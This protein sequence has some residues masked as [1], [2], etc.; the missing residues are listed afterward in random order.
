MTDN[1]L[2]TRI[3]VEQI[4]FLYR[5]VKTL[6]IGIVVTATI[7]T[8]IFYNSVDNIVLFSWLGGILLL[9]LTR[10]FV[11]RQFH[12]RERSDADVLRWGKIFTFF[13]FLSGCSWG[14]ASLLFFNPED[15]TEVLILTMVQ[16]SMMVASLASMS[17]VL[18][19]YYSFAIPVGLALMYVFMSAGSSEFFLFGALAGI[20]FAIQLSSAKVTNRTLNQTVSL[21][22]QNLD[23]IEQLE[24]EKSSSI[25]AQKKAE[26]A[27]AAKTKFL[28]AASHDLR[29]PLHAQSLF[30]GLLEPQIK[31]PN[32]KN[33]IQKIQKSN[34]ALGDLLEGLLDI[35]KLDANIIEPQPDKFALQQLFTSLHN[36]FE[37]VADE[38]NLLL[39]FVKTQHWINTD[40]HILDR[41]LRNIIGN[42]I[43][44]TNEGGV[45]IGVRK[46]GK[47][48]AIC[49]Y[50]SGI[51]IPEDKQE[52]VFLEFQQ[53]NNHER[54]RTK[55][56]GL[57]LAIVRRL[58]QLLNAKL[59][60]RS[61]EDK[62][63]CFSIE[64]Q[65]VSKQYVSCRHTDEKDLAKQTA[66]KTIVIIDD[67][68][69][70]LTSLTALLESWGHHVIPATS[71]REA[72]EKLDQVE[73]PPDM[74]LTDYRL[75][76]SETGAD[77]IKAVNSR[78]KQ[79]IPAT[80]I[81]GDT[82]P[83]RIKEAKDSGYSLLHKP[84]SANKLAR[85]IHPAAEKQG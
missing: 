9:T 43:R 67:E 23:L 31:D 69:D 27:N 59:E 82:A 25:K 54:D 80:I 41:I 30:L 34:D 55:G 39:H 65:P 11:F 74:I 37:A 48:I 60:I 15:S 21:R 13:M 24:E 77:V 45:V 84:V 51:G 79:L 40:K 2:Q 50:D 8:V 46:R 44:Y 28:A 47:K 1:S 32:Q 49:V 26:T 83:D 68:I 61:R 52:D 7:L 81:T 66:N 72:I 14:A 22:F 42:A 75:R 6:L 4:K 57:G 10:Y 29:Q 5:H 53:L 3:K 19:S 71:G 64:F 33:I 18:A 38:K 12:S 73:P 17:A 76:N 85:I 36:D 16:T 58:A 20:F 78:Y 63:S 70:I 56:F 62:G 35:S